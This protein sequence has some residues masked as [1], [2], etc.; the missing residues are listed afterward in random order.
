MSS[1]TYSKTPKE[2][3]AVHQQIYKTGRKDA[4]MDLT[5][6]QGDFQTMMDNHQTYTAGANERLSRYN[7]DSNRYFNAVSNEIVNP[8][9][10]LRKE[11]I[12]A[13][14]NVSRYTYLFDP[15][16]VSAAINAADKMNNVATALQT[17]ENLVPTLKAAIMGAGRHAKKRNRLVPPRIKTKKAVKK[18]RQ[19]KSAKMASKKKKLEADLL[20]VPKDMRHIFRSISTMTPAFKR[21]AKARALKGGVRHD[22]ST[23]ADQAR[24]VGPRNV[25]HKET[26]PFVGFAKSI[27]LMR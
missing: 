4:L 13:A 19:S 8:N 10:T 1:L 15:T 12:P 17:G 18:G 21:A 3:A 14:A 6:P 20:T 25:P 22:T 7:I 5:M 26:N 16:S 24:N 9:S 11:I 27:G 2:M 23:A